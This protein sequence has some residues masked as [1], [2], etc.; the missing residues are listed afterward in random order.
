MRILSTLIASEKTKKDSALIQNLLFSAVKAD[1]WTLVKCL[2][3]LGVD[4][5]TKN[6]D[7][8]TALI[9]AIGMGRLDPNHVKN[10]RYSIS[11]IIQ[12]GNIAKHRSYKM[13]TIAGA[14]C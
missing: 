5:N 10:N 14:W 8:E 13:Q 12:A 3:K 1:N 9:Q 6:E 4:I 2:V 7:G 11:T